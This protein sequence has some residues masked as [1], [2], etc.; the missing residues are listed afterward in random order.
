MALSREA[1]RREVVALGQ[2]LADQ[3]A[4]IAEGV[5]DPRTILDAEVRALLVAAYES[6]R[7]L[8]AQVRVLEPPADLQSV[9]QV[10][11]AGID[12][13]D[14][15]AWNRLMAAGLLDRGELQ[16]GLDLWRG[17]QPLED[18]AQLLVREA[19]E[20]LQSA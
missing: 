19:A 4:I 7:R 12:R 11:V 1:Y 17:D 16:Q 15:V 20:R 5:T 10:L 18:E 2:C 3:Y 13:Y 9:Q 6:I 8:C 14:E